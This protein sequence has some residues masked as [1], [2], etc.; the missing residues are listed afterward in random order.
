MAAMPAFSN[1]VNAA[2]TMVV[3]G[4]ER[5][6]PSGRSDTTRSNSA[7]IVDARLPPLTCEVQR[8]SPQEKVAG[9]GGRSNG[10]A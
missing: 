5:I 2:A 7:L 1:C 9:E 10:N 6:T 3:E 4:M 8:Q